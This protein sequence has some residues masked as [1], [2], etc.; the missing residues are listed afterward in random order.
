[1]TSLAVLLTLADSR[2]PTGAH[3]HSGG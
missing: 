1:M 3:V 2:L